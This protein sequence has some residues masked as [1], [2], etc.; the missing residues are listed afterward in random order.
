MEQFGAD[1]WQG[2][3]ARPQVSVRPMPEGALPP[4]WI[5]V[6]HYARSGAYTRYRGPDGERRDSI[7]AVWRTYHGED[8]VPAADHIQT[9]PSIPPSELQCAIREHMQRHRLSQH[10]VCQAIGEHASKLSQ[11]LN[12]K[13]QFGGVGAARLEAKLREY[14]AVPAQPDASATVHHS[15]AILPIG[16][17]RYIKNLI[18]RP[19]VNGFPA[20][21]SGF[22]EPSGRYLMRLIATESELAAAS[23]DEDLLVN[24]LGIK[25]ANL[26]S[27]PPSPELTAAAAT[28]AP[29]APGDVVDPAAAMPV[30][31]HADGYTQL[32]GEGAPDKKRP[33]PEPASHSDG[34]GEGLWLDAVT[35]TAGIGGAST[36]EVLAE[37][38][39]VYRVEALLAV[40]HK[41]RPGGGPRQFLVHW[42]GFPASEATW[43]EEQNIL[44]ERLIA[45]FEGRAAAADGALDGGPGCQAAMPTATEQAQA[46][47]GAAEGG[48]ADDVFEVTAEDD[49]EDVLGLG[50]GGDAADANEGAPVAALP[51]SSVV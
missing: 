40:R 9:V 28:V 21:V 23:L 44:D 48:G 37:A 50:E 15:S 10:D 8:H 30:G 19:E 45:A 32:A 4:G 16:T 41:G 3:G 51:E 31:E 17:K 39:G 25:P 27:S 46:A 38:E 35:T 6:V 12:G 13:V 24:E 26:A 7:K 5:A 33:R 47:E 36:E 11:W 14:L 43:E 34:I 18:S 2:L 22:D 49:E 42:R 20:I 29:P 1:D